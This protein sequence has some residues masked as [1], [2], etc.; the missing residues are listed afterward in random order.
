MGDKTDNLLR[1]NKRGVK[2]PFKTDIMIFKQKPCKTILLPTG[3]VVY[4][5][6]DGTINVEKSK[7]EKDN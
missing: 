2:T 6:K 1:T 4:H 5:Y 7:D 3:I